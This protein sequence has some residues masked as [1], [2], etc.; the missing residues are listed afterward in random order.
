MDMHRVIV[1]PIE[2]NCYIIES[3][4]KTLVIDPGDDFEVIRRALGDRVPSLVIVTHRHWDHLGA[5]RELVEYSGAEVWCH[6]LDA[7]AAL[8]SGGTGAMTRGIDHSISHIDRRLADGDIIDF[9]DLHFEVLHTPG[10]SIG[11]ICLYEPAEHALFSGDT[12]FL[13]TVGRT[14]FETGS[15]EDMRRS[16]NRLK[17][18]PEDVD[19]YPG[20]GDFTT[21][22][23]ERAVNMLMR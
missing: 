21:I 14:D 23:H 10:H 15:L 5:V 2:T 16:C 17:Q 18:L 7:D 12:L 20:H 19:V 4:G 1:G 11:S 13:G 8:T 9:G 3:A 22:G 6:E